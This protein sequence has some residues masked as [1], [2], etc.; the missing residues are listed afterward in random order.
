MIK[1]KL[2]AFIGIILLLSSCHST[3]YYTRLEPRTNTVITGY[4]EV[5]TGEKLVKDA[6]YLGTAYDYFKGEKENAILRELGIPTLRD[7]DGEGGSILVYEN[8]KYEE[9][10]NVPSVGRKY[11][12]FFVN[13]QGSCY[14]VVSSSHYHKYSEPVYEPIY[15]QKP[16]YSTETTTETVTYT[17]R[18]FKKST[19]WLCLIPPW[20][21]PAMIIGIERSTNDCPLCGE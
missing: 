21:L 15:T 16:I 20:W 19:W 3:E 18:C 11:V 6:E 13:E 8:I 7:V 2:L 12:N 9:K 4:K 17:Q 5:K 1:S 10:T 14:D